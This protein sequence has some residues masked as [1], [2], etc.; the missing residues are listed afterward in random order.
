MSDYIGRAAYTICPRCGTRRQR[1]ATNA[2][3]L[4]GDCR[5]VE[6]DW[7]NIGSPQAPVDECLGFVGQSA[8][9]SRMTPDE[10]RK[11]LLSLI[12]LRAKINREIAQMEAVVA[13]IK[14]RKPAAVCGTDSGYTRHVKPRKGE[15]KTEPC[16]P[17]KRAHALAERRRIERRNAE[18]TQLR[19]VS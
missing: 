16:E 3:Q 8:K 18:Q 19:S 2:G 10:A 11:R 1:G 7:P 17:C 5:Y 12:E 13:N 4:C 15:P 14:I 9:A 6:P